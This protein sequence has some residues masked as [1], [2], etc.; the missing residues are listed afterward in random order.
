M[1]PSQA[2]VSGGVMVGGMP[3]RLLFVAWFMTSAT[4]TDAPP[5][6]STLAGQDARSV[7]REGGASCF[8]R[9]APSQGGWSSKTLLLSNMMASREPDRV[10]LRGSTGGK[11]QQLLH[12]CNRT[13]V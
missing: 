6:P 4:S 1:N 5:P 13:T 8:H 9:R 3:R 2:L 10:T 7:L 11:A 12:R